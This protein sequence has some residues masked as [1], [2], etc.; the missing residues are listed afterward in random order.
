LIL[1]VDQL[2]WQAMDPCYDRIHLGD[3]HFDLVAG[4]DNFRN[5]LIARFPQEQAAIDEYI[6]PFRQSCR[7]DAAIYRRAYV[8]KTIRQTV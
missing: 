4:R 7:R 8:T 1:S 5:N 6:S 2:Q 3:D